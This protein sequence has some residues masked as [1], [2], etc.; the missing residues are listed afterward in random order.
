MI[1]TLANGM[2]EERDGFDAYELR[3]G[4]KV[5]VKLRDGQWLRGRVVKHVIPE[6]MI[7][8]D[9]PMCYEAESVSELVVTRK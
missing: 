6:W 7:L 4:T 8:Q 5:D 1:L 3:G 9:D 2:S